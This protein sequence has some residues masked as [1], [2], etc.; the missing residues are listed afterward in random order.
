MICVSVYYLDGESTQI[1]WLRARNDDVGPTSGG[2]RKADQVRTKN[3][4][5][6]IIND[7]IN[8]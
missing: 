6:V 1:K 4:A 2:C 8:M 7:A 3:I 5:Y